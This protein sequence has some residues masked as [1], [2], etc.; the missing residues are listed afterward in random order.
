MPAMLLR[1]TVSR[2][3]P[4]PSIVRLLLTS[5]SSLVSLIGLTTWDISK[6]IVLP[7]QAPL[8]IVRKEPAPLSLL[9]VTNVGPHG[10]VKV[11]GSELPATPGSS[12]RQLSSLVP[13][14]SASYFIV[15]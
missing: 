4:G 2:F 15:P 6:V 3:A 11:V 5:N 14:P 7:G 9:L 10:P 12:V 13:S 1:I 8:M